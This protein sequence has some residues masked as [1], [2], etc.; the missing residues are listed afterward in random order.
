MNCRVLGRHRFLSVCQL[1]SAADALH[2]KKA[3]DSNMYEQPECY[4]V[5]LSDLRLHRIKAAWLEARRE[6]LEAGYD[7]MSRP[8]WLCGQEL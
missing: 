2:V 5:P 8:T 7:M 4:D 3:V 6:H 1:A